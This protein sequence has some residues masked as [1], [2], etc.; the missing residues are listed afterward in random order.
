MVRDSPCFGQN[1]APR[2]VVARDAVEHDGRIAPAAED[3]ADRHRDIRGRETRRRNL[4]KQWLKQVVVP[5]IDERYAHRRV[6]QSLRRGEPAEAGAGNDDVRS[7]P[8]RSVCG[9]G[10]PF[11]R[12][13][14][15]ALMVLAYAVMPVATSLT[16]GVGS[17]QAPTTISQSRRA[18]RLSARC[19]RRASTTYTGD[20]FACEPSHR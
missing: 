9:L 13:R 11:R 8:I 10:E 15:C 20:L 2:R 5:S 7:C 18:I 19:R 14:R 12:C 3:A 4:V 17:R 16:L 6:G 1:H